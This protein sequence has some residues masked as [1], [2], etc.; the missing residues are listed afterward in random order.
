MNNNN[1]IKPNI[2]G[3]HAWKFM[4][5]V[6]LNYP[7]NPTIDNKN[8]YKNFYYSLQDI[9]PCEKCRNNYK[10]NIIDHPIDPHLENKNSLIK[11]VIDIHN[12]VNTELNKPILEHKEAT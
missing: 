2:W 4:H 5:Y 3:P 10:Q 1:S 8:R 9:L 12:K 6:S 11:W 7:E